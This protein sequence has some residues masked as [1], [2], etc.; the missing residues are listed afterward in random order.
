MKTADQILNEVL[1]STTI[2]T[3]LTSD[4]VLNAI[5]SAAENALRINISGF[6]SDE[7]WSPVVL[8]DTAIDASTEPNYPE[9]ERGY[10]FLISV[11]G[12]IGGASGIAVEAGDIVYCITDSE[13]GTQAEVGSEWG[14]I[15]NN[16]IFETETSNLKENGTAALGSSGKVANS[17]HVHPS[18][19]TKVSHSLAIA[20][21]DFLVGDSSPFGQWVK[22]TL[23]EV[24]TLLSWVLTSTTEAIGFTISG[25][26]DS[27]T[28][29]IDEDVT[30]SSK[31]NKAIP[32]TAKNFAGL[33]GGTGQLEDSLITPVVDIDEFALSGGTVI[34]VTLTVDETI[35]VSE[36]ATLGENVT[37]ETITAGEPIDT[38]ALEYSIW[39]I[40]D[41]NDDVVAKV[42]VECSNIGN[43]TQESKIAF[44]RMI[45][46]TLTKVFE[47]DGV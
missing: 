5:Y 35:K 9:G 17:D 4:Q 46:G 34:P 1:S 14:I 7:T 6:P 30:I 16:V 15:Q 29:T 45:A 36:K 21:N 31:A 19:S 24:K 33:V 28:L 32:A 44:Y 42:V 38:T 20:E 2:T 18:D 3:Y 8:R 12:K 37:F 10:L 40:K 43:G 47:I 41:I 27:K 22:K 11:A 26:T 13:G 25:G 39:E 23:L